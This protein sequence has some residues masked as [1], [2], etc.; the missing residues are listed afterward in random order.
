MTPHTAHPTAARDAAPLLEMRSIRKVFGA[1]TVLRDVSLQCRAGQVHAICGENGAGK[2]TLMKVLGGIHAPDGGEMRIG[3]RPVRFGHPSAARQA[4]IAI[5]HQELALLPHRTVAQNIFLGHEPSRWGVIDRK[6]MNA[7]A[8]AA[9]RRVGCRIDPRTE[10]GRLSVAEQQMVEIA[11]AVSLDARILVLDEPTAALDDVESRKLFDLIAE[12]RRAG[13]AMLYISHRMAEVMALADD[14]SVIKDG[15]LMATLP[16]AEATV[17]RIV[18][19]MVGRELSDFYPPAAANPPGAEVFAV[20]QGGNEVL[21]GIDLRLHAGEIVGVAGLEASGKVELARALFGERRFT[22]GTVRAWDDKGAARSP[23]E[24]ARRGIGY[25]PDDRKREGLGLQ[26]SLRDNAA[27]TL[28]ALAGPLAGAGSAA[29]SRSLIDALLNK[30]EVRAADFDRPVGALSG[31]NQQRVMV[32]RWMAREPRLWVICE[33]TRGIDVGAKAT[34]YRL[35]RAYADAGGAVLV[36][37]SDVAEIIGLCDRICVMALGRIVAHLP[38]G[39]SEE[40]VIAQ[41]VRHDVAEAEGA[42]A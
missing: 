37:S 34:I 23:R 3:G 4:G 1:V 8:E 33:P 38:R 13:V 32:A 25:L 21:H 27:L 11:K 15:Q 24:A 17:E 16:A 12:L 41:A 20:E 26:Q 10:C 42:A 14:I 35:L 28:R 19:L 40:A 5:I 30:V 29:R 39:A 9:L 22:R 7:G 36:V 6:A 31:C 18:R 2:S